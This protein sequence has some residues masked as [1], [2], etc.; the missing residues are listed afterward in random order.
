MLPHKGPKMAR[1]IIGAAVLLVFCFKPAYASAG[2]GDIRY[3]SILKFCAGVVAAFSIHEGG[4]ALVGWVTG[5][6]MDWEWGDINQ[7]LRFTEDSE[8][9]TEGAA[10]NLAGLIAQAIGGEVIL[11]VDKIDK[12]DAFVQGMMAWNI[13][14]PILYALDYWCCHRTNHNNGDAYEGD[15]AGVERYTSEPTANAFALSMAGIAAFQASRFL[16]TQSWAS[17]WFKNKSHSINFGPLPS[18]G[19]IMR[20]EIVF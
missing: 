13:L 9:D 8:S 7:P 1:Y 2:E 17:D 5:T 3:T 12:N 16:K 10:I 6:D 15:L 14:N 20:Y 18:G 11:R 19:L 4:H